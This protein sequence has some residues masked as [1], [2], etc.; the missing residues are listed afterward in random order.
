MKG[1]LRPP[2][3]SPILPHERKFCPAVLSHIKTESIFVSE[4]CKCLYHG[5]CVSLSFW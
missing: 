5:V 1:A 2:S 3:G 4:Q